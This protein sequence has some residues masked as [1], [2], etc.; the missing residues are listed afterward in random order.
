MKMFP[1]PE[2][3]R[4][5]A[6]GNAKRFGYDAV[7]GGTG[8]SGRGELRNGFPRKLMCPAPI[9]LVQ[10]LPS[11]CCT[12]VAR[13]HLIIVLTRGQMNELLIL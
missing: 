13:R 2:L 12:P 5:A 9:H 6:G 10:T 3:R 7:P 4:G 11:F 1:F 8:E